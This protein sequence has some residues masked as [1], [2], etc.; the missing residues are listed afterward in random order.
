[1]SKFNNSLSL[2]DPPFFTS[3]F[4]PPPPSLPPPHAIPRLSL[5]TT[6]PL[7]ST[8]FLSPSDVEGQIIRR[9]FSVWALMKIS[10]KCFLPENLSFPF[11]PNR[12]FV[13]P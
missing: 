4:L 2:T 9:S 1:M 8:C 11:F 12:F 7:R 13:I 3:F 6:F 10:V 5:N